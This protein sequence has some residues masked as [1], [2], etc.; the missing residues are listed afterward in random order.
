MPSRAII[1]SP[2]TLDAYQWHP[3]PDPVRKPAVIPAKAG[4]RRS[5]HGQPENSCFRSRGIA[6]FKDV[7]R[8]SSGHAWA[9]IGN[10]QDA[11]RRYRPGRTLGVRALP[12][13][14]ASR[15]GAL[16]GTRP[17]LGPK[18]LLGARSILG[19]KTL[20]GTHALL[21]PKALLGKASLGKSLLGLAPVRLASMLV[22]IA[23]YASSR[24]RRVLRVREDPND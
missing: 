8:P 6:R 10:S 22:V 19:P 3:R 5:C 17:I 12:V 7:G 9:W 18:A 16:L 1:K 21:G 2:P 13:L 23:A 20:L 14:V 4:K 24:W 11:N 15:S